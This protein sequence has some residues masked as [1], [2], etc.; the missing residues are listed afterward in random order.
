MGTYDENILDKI[1]DFLNCI[2]GNSIETVTIWKVL[3]AHSLKYFNVPLRPDSVQKGV[4]IIS[5]IYH[6]G[7]AVNWPKIDVNDVFQTPTFF[8]PDNLIDIKPRIKSLP[9]V[10][11]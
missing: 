5:I 1:I 9:P 2:L 3:S 7:I 6:C 11:T 4:F 8:H 10:F